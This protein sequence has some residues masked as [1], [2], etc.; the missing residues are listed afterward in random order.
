[1]LYGRYFEFPIRTHGLL[2]RGLEPKLRKSLGAC[3]FSVS[4]RI[5]QIFEISVPDL[6]LADCARVSK[7]QNGGH[8]TTRDKVNLIFYF[9]NGCEGPLC[10]KVNKLRQARGKE[11]EIIFHY[12][13]GLSQKSVT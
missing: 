10:L 8:K 9:I 12:Q 2:V 7:I 4:D 3:L 1:M 5:L 11:R 13:F 6:A